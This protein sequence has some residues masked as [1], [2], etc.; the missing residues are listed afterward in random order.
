VTLSAKL[1]E[2]HPRRFFGEAFAIADARRDEALKSGGYPAWKPFAVAAIGAV[3]LLALQ[4]Y[5]TSQYL[6]E[7]VAD[8]QRTDPSWREVHESAY[9]R[10]LYGKIWWTSWRVAGYLVLPALFAK[11]VLKERLRDH[12]LGFG[13]VRDHL[14]IY[15]VAIAIVLPMVFG[16][17]YL[18]SFQRKY[19]MYEFAGRSWSDFL[20]WTAMYSAQFL[21]LEFFFRGHWLRAFSPVMGGHAITAMI[22]PY[23]MIHMNK[24]F[25]EAVGSI[26]AGLALGA[27]AIRSR[28]IYPGFFV[29]ATIGFS[30][31]LAAL[32]QKGQ[33]PSS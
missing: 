10:E 28:S 24:P 23:A 16:V 5:G 22:I 14:W 19:P 31:D 12:G 6:L 20:L 32:A 4:K 8:W 2:L 25:G 15:L 1:A 3:V 33:W 27:L 30:M 7:L 18:D 17:S 29:H 9:L 21:A 26:A 11:L 13:H